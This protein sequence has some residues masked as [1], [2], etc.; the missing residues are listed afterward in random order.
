MR[1]SNTTPLKWERFIYKGTRTTTTST[2]AC[3]RLTWPNGTSVECTKNAAGQGQL[4]NTIPIFRKE[5]LPERP[6]LP[7]KTRPACSW[8][9]GTSVFL[10]PRRG[11][12]RTNLSIGASPV[13]INMMFTNLSSQ[14]AFGTG[15]ILPGTLDNHQDWIA[16]GDIWHHVVRV[17]SKDGELLGDYEK[18]HAIQ[19]ANLQNTDLVLLDADSDPPLAKLQDLAEYLE[20][21]RKE[22]ETQSLRKGGRLQE[23]DGFRFDPSLKVKGMRFSAVIAPPPFARKLKQVR[24]FLHE[25]H[26]VQLQLSFS[27]TAD[28]RSY[29]EPNE[30]NPIPEKHRGYERRK[31]AVSNRK[32]VMNNPNANINNSLHAD[33]NDPAALEGVDA[34]FANAGWT[35]MVELARRILGEVRDIAR[36]GP[37][38]PCPEAV[39]VHRVTAFLN[40]WPGVANKNSKLAYRND[41]W[42]E[43]ELLSVLHRNMVY[44]DGKQVRQ[45]SKRN[46]TRD[47][48][49]VSKNGYV[50]NHLVPV[51]GENKRRGQVTRDLNRGSDAGA[52]R[53]VGTAEPDF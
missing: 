17:V 8:K 48:L 32:Y 53:G 9:T 46:R 42:G 16:N 31:A 33:D 11:A 35:L 29:R 36:L 27:P 12:T 40:L 47:A 50:R 52:R 5:E 20:A 26:R 21:K 23:V 37:H 51:R 22:N 18:E 13:H 39:E 45:W 7:V 2:F 34:S 1:A 3:S 15:A 44:S 10:P 25:G 14:R 28:E 49:A 41:C 43:D 24:S 38:L 30:T 6:R 4:I 19:L